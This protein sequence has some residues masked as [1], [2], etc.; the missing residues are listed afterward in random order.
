MAHGCSMVAAMLEA[1]PTVLGGHGVQG[2]PERLPQR[3][4]GP[5]PRRAEPP[6]ALGPDLLARLEV[7]RLR[8][9]SPAPRPRLAKGAGHRPPRGTLSRSSTP[10]SPGR[11][12]GIS[13]CL[14]KVRNAASSV[15]PANT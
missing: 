8:R 4:G 7:R 3:L 5:R 10:I 9:Q 11:R 14:T 13:T 2:L 1:P 15:A 6:L 12:A